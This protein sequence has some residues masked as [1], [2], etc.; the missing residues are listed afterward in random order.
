[1]NE[2]GALGIH[3]GQRKKSQPPAWPR[4]IWCA[5]ALAHESQPRPR[6]SPEVAL[7]WQAEQWKGTLESLAPNGR[8]ACGILSVSHQRLRN[9]SQFPHR[10]LA[11]LSPEGVFH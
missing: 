9:A 6:L 4:P 3:K 2:E 7:E 10:S 1:M 11:A 5:G 8:P